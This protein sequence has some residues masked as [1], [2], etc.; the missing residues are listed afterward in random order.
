MNSVDLKVYYMVIK[1]SVKVYINYWGSVREMNS[2]SVLYLRLVIG[3]YYFVK[4][5]AYFKAV[6]MR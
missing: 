4:H 2:L 1:G 6:H 3:A 5:N